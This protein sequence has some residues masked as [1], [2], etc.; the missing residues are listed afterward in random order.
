MAL[1]PKLGEWFDLEE[2]QITIHNGAGCAVIF[3]CKEGD[4]RPVAFADTRNLVNQHTIDRW[5]AFAATQL[6]TTH[7]ELEMA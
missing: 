6:A 3:A 1:Y 7:A 5:K 2:D 4:V